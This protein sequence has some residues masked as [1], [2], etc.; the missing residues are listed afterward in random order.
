MA[1]IRNAT[2]FSILSNFGALLIGFGLTIAVSR[3]LAPAEI[4]AFA[5]TYALISILDRLR[6]LGI[7]SY[8]VQ[9]ET[10]DARLLGSLFGTSLLL[11]I[12]CGAATI[13]LS[14]WIASL[15]GD[16][17]LWAMI[18]VM[19]AAFFVAPLTVPAVASLQ[20]E[21]QFKGLIGPRLGSAAV[22]AAVTIGLILWGGG[23]LSLAWGWLAGKT[24]ETLFFAFV[25]STHGF[26]R[27]NL[28]D[29]RPILRFGMLTSA[30]QLVSSFGT[31]ATEIATGRFIGLAGVGFYSRGNAVLNL[32]LAG[33]QS[34]VLPVAY[35]AFAREARSER[36]DIKSAY[37]GAI[38]H[39]SA[40]GWPAFAVFGL[41]AEPLTLILF[42]ER[43]RPSIPVAEI[44]ALAGCI[45]LLASPGPR[46]LVAV[47]RVDMLLKREL[48]IQ[49][50][51]I[52]LVVVAAHHSIEAV[53]WA[54]VLTYALAFVVNQA[55]LRQVAGI[56]YRDMAR[57]ARPSFFLAIVTA[58]PAWAGAWATNMAGPFVQLAVGLL[59]AAAF[60]TAGLFLLGH[61]TREEF[62]LVARKIR[63]TPGGGDSL[64]SPT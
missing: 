16:A 45:Y 41:L 36:R 1:S 10:L 25:K 9:S 61:P 7:S 57:A 42:G 44:L 23:A 28:H 27:P 21:L 5:V 30:S 6:D 13:L 56:G 3:L 51:R 59:L 14:P 22:R 20:R 52:I 48:A 37:L 46:F 39:L 8:G 26:V 31:A 64:Q 62:L 32:Y 55:A 54:I 63:R 17:S 2:A 60:W 11:S 4:G 18:A 50:P 12:A 33:V 40:L 34:A 19:A 38:A 58:G 47:G 24:A 15:L 35:A 43:W 49:I 53:A 29:W